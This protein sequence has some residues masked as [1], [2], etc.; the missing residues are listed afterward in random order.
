MKK[1]GIEGILVATSPFPPKMERERVD[2]AVDT[3]REV[4][5]SVDSYKGIWIASGV[6]DRE[7]ERSQRKVLVDRLNEKGVGQEKIIQTGGEDTFGNIEES[8][9]V[10]NEYNIRNLGISSYL[11]HLMR[12]ALIVDY[13]KEINELD[14]NTTIFGINNPYFKWS[15]KR[16]FGLKDIAALG[17]EEKRID[18]LKS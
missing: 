16:F 7:Y 6:L 11:M 8:I 4:Y 1:K 15:A 14:C 12:F 13:F 2:Y 5:G 17:L 18:L 9:D 10:L 3:I